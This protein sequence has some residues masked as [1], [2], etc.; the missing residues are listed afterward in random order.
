LCERT[1]R[2]DRHQRRSAYKCFHSRS[3]CCLRQPRL[4]VHV[5]ADSTFAPLERSVLRLCLLAD[6]MRPQFSCRGLQKTR[7]RL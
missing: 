7:A 2:Y 6:W 5:P 3:P 4:S 1:A